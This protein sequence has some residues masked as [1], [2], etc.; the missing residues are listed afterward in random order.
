MKSAVISEKKP[1]KKSAN[2]KTEENHP[3]APEGWENFNLQKAYDLLG[4]LLSNKFDCDVWF[5]PADE[6]NGKN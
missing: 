5:V 3:P 1:R 4:K 6:N 2:Y